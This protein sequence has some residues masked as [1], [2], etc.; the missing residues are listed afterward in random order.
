MTSTN[1]Y[2]PEMHASQLGIRIIDACLPAGTLALW[3]E[4]TR[5]ILASP[6]LLRRQRRCVIAHELAHA[7]NGDT[8][9]LLDDVAARKRERRAD[10]T[11][12]G[13]LLDPVAVR[14]A[15]AVSPDSLSAAAADLDVTPR[16]L[17]AWLE[18]R[19]GERW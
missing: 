1:T 19:K 14:T 11:A 13:W 6:G 12:A 3:D 10:L 8:H 17:S 9:A 7:V 5:T 18:G 16:I 2:N 4:T 15:L